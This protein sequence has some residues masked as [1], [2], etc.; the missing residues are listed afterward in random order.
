MSNQPDSP[1]PAPLAAQA[2]AHVSTPA[3][4]PPPAPDTPY[5]SLTP[6]AELPP[7]PAHIT[8]DQ[9]ARLEAHGFDPADYDWE[10]VFKRPRHDGW[11]VD[12][13]RAFIATLADTGSVTQAAAAAGMAKKSAYALRRAP[14]AQG[15]ARAWAM[16]LQAASQCLADTAFERALDGVDDPVLDA[17]GTVIHVRTKRS[18]QLLMFLLRA[19]QP[20]IYGNGRAARP[21]SSSIEFDLAK[22]GWSIVGGPTKDKQ[23][24]ATP[25]AAPLPALLAQPDMASAIDALGPATPTD[26]PAAMNNYARANLIDNLDEEVRF[27]QRYP[28]AR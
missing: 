19:H 10:P 9:R 16:A 28:D 18:D 21:Q 20:H 24:D 11:T 25:A 5:P 1:A 27:R 2:A 15:F 14:G 4:A 17:E 7:P 12:R 23:D 26:P 8:P 13:Q 6:D 3:V 22:T